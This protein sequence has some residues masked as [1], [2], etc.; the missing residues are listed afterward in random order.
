[1]TNDVRERTVRE[2]GLL[3][4]FLRPFYDIVIPLA[5]PLARLAC[6]FHLTVHGWGKILRGGTVTGWS[7]SFGIFLTFI[8][9]VGGVCIT[10]GLFTR[11]FAAAVSIEMAYLTFVQYWPKGYGWRTDGY[12]YVLMWGMLSFAIVLRGGGNYSLDRAIGREL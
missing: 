11:F 5:W 3:L 2:P 10:L 8:E 6:G 7:L 1:M 4:P 9:F 12:E